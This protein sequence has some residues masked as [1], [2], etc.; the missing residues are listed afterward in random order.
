ML[1][2]QIKYKMKKRMN[3]IAFQLRI[4]LVRF[5]FAYPVMFLVYLY[6]SKYT[7]LVK[8]RFVILL[9]KKDD[10]VGDFPFVSS[11]CLLLL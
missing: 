2:F 1:N 10:T 7:L 9:I 8:Y 4:K 5:Y 6:F 3:G 11:F